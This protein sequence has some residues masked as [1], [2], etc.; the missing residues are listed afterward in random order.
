V[1]RSLA[2]DHG[3]WYPWVCHMSSSKE[4]RLSM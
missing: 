4:P 3:A 1:A 2:N